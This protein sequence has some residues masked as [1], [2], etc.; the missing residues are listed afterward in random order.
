[1]EPY[2]VRYTLEEIIFAQGMECYYMKK[3]GTFTIDS[4]DIE[5]YR[6]LR[7]YPYIRSIPYLDQIKTT[8]LFKL[9]MLAK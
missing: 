9:I 4:Y 7:Q 8:K 1:M 6:S 3:S 2:Q 5:L